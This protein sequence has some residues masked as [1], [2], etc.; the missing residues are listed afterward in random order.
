MYHATVSE[1]DCRLSIPRSSVTIE[2]VEPAAPEA[3]VDS[4]RPSSSAHRRPMPTSLTTK[5]LNTLSPPLP[6]RDHA[7]LPR[8]AL[9]ESFCE[10]SRDSRSSA[11]TDAAMV[12]IAKLRFPPAFSFRVSFRGVPPLASRQ[13]DALLRVEKREARKIAADAANNRGSLSSPIPGRKGKREREMAS[14]AVSKARRSEAEV[15][16]LKRPRRAITEDKSID[17]QLRGS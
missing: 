16:S 11:R 8:E 13:T 14:G 5:R 9:A 3:A 17:S 10:K 2:S 4:R 7:L 6:P 1:R 15:V 12:E